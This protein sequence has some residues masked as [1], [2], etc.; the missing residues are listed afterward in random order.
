MPY[1]TIAGSVPVSRVCYA[2][3]FVPADRNEARKPQLQVWQE[4]WQTFKRK[5]L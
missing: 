4:R 2:S 1:L 3:A 5:Q